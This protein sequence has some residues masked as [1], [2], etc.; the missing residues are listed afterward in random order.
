MV[1]NYFEA[2]ASASTSS[3][4]H[5]NSMQFMRI[6]EGIQAPQYLEISINQ[7]IFSGQTCYSIL[8]KDISEIIELEQERKKDVYMQMLVSS[9]SH[10]FNNP[11]NILMNN[12]EDQLQSLG[13]N[14][15][16]K[17][18]FNAT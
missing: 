17:V 16:L 12:L 6:L 7:V 10:E 3:L 4:N 14:T 9:I 1:D 15:S 11:L 13:S 18:C 8:L 5:S 2:N